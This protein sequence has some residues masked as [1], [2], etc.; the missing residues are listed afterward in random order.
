[1]A[2]I[3]NLQPWRF[4]SIKEIQEKGDQFEY[5]SVR[6]IGRVNEFKT[7]SKL[8]IISNEGVSMTMNISLVPDKEMIIRKKYEF[9]GELK[10]VS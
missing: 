3:P 5:E 8:A 4:T 10:K 2:N 6:I 1:M 7:T 9:L